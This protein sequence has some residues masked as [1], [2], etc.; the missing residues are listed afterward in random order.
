MVALLFKLSNEPLTPAG[1]PENITRLAL[2]V[3][4]VILFIG[5]DKQ[6]V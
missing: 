4:Y 1:S 5:D 2:P 3:V 6:T